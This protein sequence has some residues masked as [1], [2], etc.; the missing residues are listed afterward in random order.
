VQEQQQQQRR[1]EE[2]P[3][4]VGRP[5]SAGSCGDYQP[6]LGQQLKLHQQQVELCA[7][8]LEQRD[9]DRQQRSPS[10]T[11]QQ[12]QQ[13]Y[14]EHAEPWHGSG[15]GEGASSRRS[16]AGA[17]AAD[18]H[19][20]E[21]RQH[22]LGGYSA[23]S[24]SAGSSVSGSRDGSPS[25]ASAADGSQD[26]AEQQLLQQQEQALHQQLYGRWANKQGVSSPQRQQ[27]GLRQEWQQWQH[28]GS[29][30]CGTPA[31]AA[32]MPRFAGE[33]LP[34]SLAALVSP[35]RVRRGTTDS[36]GSAAPVTPAGVLSQVARGSVRAVSPAVSGLGKQQGVRRFSAASRASGSGGGAGQ[37]E[38]AASGFSFGA[39]GFVGQ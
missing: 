13:R 21:R 35:G 9:R 38:G 30:V 25:R 29:P 31:A 24:S 28:P 10:P 23:S 5:G 22:I 7:F 32:A 3:V 14:Y 12:Q 16:A 15:Q 33:G 20:S 39:W 2:G 26:V 1:G 19:W 34:R 36:A 27:Q 4:V 11:R 8:Q 37:A 18:T 17:A 6:L